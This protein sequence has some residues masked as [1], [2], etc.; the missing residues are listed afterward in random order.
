MYKAT[1]EIEVTGSNLSELQGVT[2]LVYSELK[3]CRKTIYMKE[4][5]S[6]DIKVTYEED[7]EYLD[8]DEDE[9]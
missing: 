2:G 6:C 8:H 1:I 9:I 7:G 3:N 4:V 5:E